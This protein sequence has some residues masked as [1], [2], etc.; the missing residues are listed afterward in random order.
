MIVTHSQSRKLNLSMLLQIPLYQIITSL[1]KS[2]PQIKC[3]HGKIKNY[4]CKIDIEEE[5]FLG[6]GDLNPV[7]LEIVVVVVGVVVVD[8]FGCGW[9][10]RHFYVSP[11]RK[12]VGRSI[13]LLLLLLDPC[14]FYIII[15][16]FL[17]NSTLDTMYR[18]VKW[19]ALVQQNVDPLLCY[20]KWFSG[21]ITETTASFDLVKHLS[22][23]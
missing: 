7:L 4:L 13:S 14:S 17:F 11:L 20:T 10:H 3:M 5:G 9:S 19:E 22:L 21:R 16:G 6:V 1:I 8:R 15:F 18:W 2:N 23:V 12:P